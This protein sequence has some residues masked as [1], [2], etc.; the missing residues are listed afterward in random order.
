MRMRHLRQMHLPRIS[1][2]LF[3]RLRNPRQI[4]ADDPLLNTLLSPQINHTLLP[5]FICRICR[6]HLK[7]LK[8]HVVFR[9]RWTDFVCRASAASAAASAAGGVP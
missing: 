3:N 1:S 5:L 2:S 6:N 7:R 8:T 9:G 4:A